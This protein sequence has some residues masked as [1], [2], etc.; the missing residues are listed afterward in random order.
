MHHQASH[1]IILSDTDTDIES[2]M[3]TI[4]RV[5][6][7]ESGRS[8]NVNTSNNGNM[9]RNVTSS[10]SSSGI[11]ATTN[12]LHSSPIKQG[13]FTISGEEE[14]E[15]EEEDVEMKEDVIKEV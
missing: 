11:S 15:E 6:D 12:K 14:E 1:G 4:D 13:H 9:E 2:G 8:H 10:N 3:E 7:I 5:V